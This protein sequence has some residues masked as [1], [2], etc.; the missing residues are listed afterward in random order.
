VRIDT[1]FEP[2]Q[3][4]I[5]GESI[6]MKVVRFADVEMQKPVEQRKN[7]KQIS[8]E[9]GCSYRY[10]A[11]LIEELCPDF[12]SLSTMMVRKVN[13]RATVSVGIYIDDEMFSHLDGEA[14]ERNLKFATILREIIEESLEEKFGY[15][16]R[17]YTCKQEEYQPNRR[18]YREK[19]RKFPILVYTRLTEDQT[20]FLDKMSYYNKGKREIQNRQKT[21]R[22]LI[23]ARYG[24]PID[25]SSRGREHN[26]DK[27]LGTKYPGKGQ[28]NAK[29]A[30]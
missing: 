9:I 5:S 19:R 10:C 7:I 22:N 29:K 30:A 24:L 17:F 27:Q 26:G 12:N 16:D 25:M 4:K 18:I 2:R 8:E 11:S 21:I 20:V 28:G 23:R 6:K 14:K 1:G 3:E 15:K 13:A